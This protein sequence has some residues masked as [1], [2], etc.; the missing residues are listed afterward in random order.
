MIDFFFDF[1]SLD[2]FV[3]RLKQQKTEPEVAA[4]LDWVGAASMLLMQQALDRISWTGKL[5]ESVGYDVNK[6]KKYVVIGPNVPTGDEPEEK[7]LTVLMGRPEAHWIPDNADTRQWAED[8][9]GSEKLIHYLRNRIAGNIKGK[10]PG[11]SRAYMIRPT[12]DF[13]F[14]TMTTSDPQFEKVF[15]EAEAEL[16]TRLVLLFKVAEE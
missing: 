2:A 9:L 5:K 14:L 16:L 1:H 13:P 3:E 8:K 4:V 7:I 11:V 6:E 15:R 10:D 12:P